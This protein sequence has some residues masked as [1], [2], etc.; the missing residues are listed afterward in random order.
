M[1][2]SFLLLMFIF[3]SGTIELTLSFVWGQSLMLG[4]TLS[5]ISDSSIVSFCLKQFAPVQWSWHGA[6]Y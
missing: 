2:S 1:C 3:Q 6:R 4:L 5:F